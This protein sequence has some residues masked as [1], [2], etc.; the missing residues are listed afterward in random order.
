MIISNKIFGPHGKQEKE[1][2]KTMWEW[3]VSNINLK[4]WP[5]SYIIKILAYLEHFKTFK[6]VPK[7]SK[8]AVQ[9]IKA[10]FSIR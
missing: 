9:N 2:M 5:N 3:K 10:I 6:I 8:N 7:K 1:V 4:V